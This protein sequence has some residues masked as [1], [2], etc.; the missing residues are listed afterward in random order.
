MLKTEH[1]PF[2][3]GSPLTLKFH[4]LCRQ[5]FPWDPPFSAETHRGL[6]YGRN[7]LKSHL[8]FQQGGL[9]QLHWVSPDTFTP[10]FLGAKFKG[11]LIFG[12]CAILHHLLGLYFTLGQLSQNPF[13]LTWGISRHLG[14]TLFNSPKR[15]KPLFSFS[16]WH[17][18][19]AGNY[20]FDTPGANL[21]N[22][23][24][25]PPTSISLWAHTGGTN[26]NPGALLKLGAQTILLASAPNWAP[27]GFYHA[28]SSAQGPFQT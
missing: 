9:P 6:T 15:G 7:G 26:T 24:L 8:D 11:D 13:G 19:S 18:F 20:Y 27:R 10:V 22:P 21:Y 23:I 14:S 17:F 3:N 16:G 1:G 2:N 5:F 25:G 4:S 28:K 12:A